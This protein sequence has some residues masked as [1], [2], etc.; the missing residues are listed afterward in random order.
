MTLSFIIGAAQSAGQKSATVFFAF[1]KGP[2]FVFQLAVAS[3]YV[4]VLISSC[5]YS[6]ILLIQHS[7]SLT[8]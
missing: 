3:R 1:E 6:L 2:P 5:S 8:F 7:Q 4:I